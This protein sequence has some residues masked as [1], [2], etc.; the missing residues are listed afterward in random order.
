MSQKLTGT[1]AVRTH[2]IN[3]G[4][5]LNGSN[6]VWQGARINAKCIKCYRSHINAWRMK[7]RERPEVMAKHKEGMRNYYYKE[8]YGITREE[9][10]KMLD[11]QQG[12]CA[13]C[14]KECITHDNLSVDHD[15]IT[16]VVRSLLCQKCNTA[17]AMLEEDEDLFWNAMEYLK[18]HKW[19]KTA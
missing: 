18:L 13:I 16:N 6:I 10:E 5:S 11:L 8:K 3:C 9:Y 7:N 4:A 19:S 12:V 17:I 1:G 15:H 2:C 14:R